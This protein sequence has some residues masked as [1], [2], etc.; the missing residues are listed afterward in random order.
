MKKILELHFSIGF[1]EKY[2]N[3]GSNA[4]IV[5]IPYP[6]VF[7]VKKSPHKVYREKGMINLKTLI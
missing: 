4:A 7:V 5:G 3:Y 6:V 1:L 2:E